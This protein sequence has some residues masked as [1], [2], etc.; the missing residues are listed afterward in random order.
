MIERPPKQSET[1]SELRT[2]HRSL[3]AVAVFFWVYLIIQAI[4]LIP[5]LFTRYGMH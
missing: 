4:V 2:M 3:F 1:P 5:A